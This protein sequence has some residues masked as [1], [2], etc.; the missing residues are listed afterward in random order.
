MP[1]SRRRRPR[2]RFRRRTRR[3]G[4]RRFRRTGRRIG[5]FKRYLFKR[6]QV[7]TVNFNLSTNTY[8]FNSQ[9]FELDNLP[10][11]TEFTNLFDQYRIN[12]IKYQWIPN[13]NVNVIVGSDISTPLVSEYDQGIPLIYSFIDYDDA[14]TPTTID[15][16]TQRQNMRTAR[17]NKPHKRVWKPTVLVPTYRTGVTFGYSPKRKQWIDCANPDVPHYGLKWAF[18]N[19]ATADATHHRGIAVSFR[20]MATYYLQ[21][22]NVR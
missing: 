21:F 1:R 11:Y 9:V 14:T 5:R 8:N 17:F 12:L 15:E 20:V 4:R 10:D 6:S 16:F 2:R 19:T 22:R 7:S 18:Y 3:I 13:R